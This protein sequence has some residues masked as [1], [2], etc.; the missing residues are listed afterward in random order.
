MNFDIFL[1]G[2]INVVLDE[3]NGIDNEEIYEKE[4]RIKISMNK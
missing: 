1:N 3:Y 4:M 2:N